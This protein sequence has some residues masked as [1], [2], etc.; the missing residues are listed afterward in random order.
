MV[1]GC[2]KGM[3]YSSLVGGGGYGKNPP[4]GHQGQGHRQIDCN[5]EN[6]IWK[7]NTTIENYGRFR[8]SARAK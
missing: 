4:R 1:V 8:C 6:K 5:A 7:W 3:A 2:G